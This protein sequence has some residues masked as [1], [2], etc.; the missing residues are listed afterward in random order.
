MADSAT[1]HYH[2]RDE[3]RRCEVKRLVMLL[4]A[5]VVAVEAHAVIVVLSGGKRLDVASYTVNAS[6]VTVQ[7]AN[8]RRESYPVT[9]VNLVATSAANGE[10]APPPQPMADSGPHSPILGAKSSARSGALVVTDA[11]V[12]HIEAAGEEADAEKKEEQVDLGSQVVLVSYDKKMTGKGQWQ[13][14]ATVAN[15]GK[16]TVQS[17]SA[18]VRILDQAGKPV[19]SGAGT[20]PGKLEPGKQGT[21]TAGVTMEGEPLQVAVD[22]N[23][24][25]IKSVPTPGVSPAPS[26]SKPQPAGAGASPGPKTAS[27]KPPTASPNTYAPNVMGVVPPTTLGTAPQVPP[28]EQPGPK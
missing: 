1:E 8:G 14:T 21:I 25:E 24:Q 23:W 10:K 22:L 28:Q 11:D 3:L 12:T 9:T 2:G 27:T 16:A 18:V 20:L 26:G 17:V 7:Y 6:Y 4:A 15:Q 19:A 13:I 5:L